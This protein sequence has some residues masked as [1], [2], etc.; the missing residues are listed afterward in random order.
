MPNN[1]NKDSRKDR[2]SNFVSDNKVRLLGL[3]ERLESINT[4][5]RKAEKPESKTQNF[6]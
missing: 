1:S 4:S 5:P 6:K 2:T 3:A